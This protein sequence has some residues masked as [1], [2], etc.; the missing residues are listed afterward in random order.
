MKIE[1]KL[2]KLENKSKSLKKTKKIKIRRQIEEYKNILLYN[3]SL[4]IILLQ[5]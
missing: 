4:M 3:Y 5:S 2:L 1:K